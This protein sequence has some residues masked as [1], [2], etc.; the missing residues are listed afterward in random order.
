MTILPLVD[1]F[2]NTDKYQSWVGH[3][4]P[5]PPEINGGLCGD[6]AD[7]VVERRGDLQTMSTA[8]VLGVSEDARPDPWHVWVTDGTRHY[9]AEAPDGVEKWT[10]LPYFKRTL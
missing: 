6:F 3:T 10:E 4:N 8:D 9:D 5:E 7:F 1:D 2:A